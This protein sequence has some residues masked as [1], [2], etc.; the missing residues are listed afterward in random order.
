MWPAATC[1][2]PTWSN[3]RLT[4]RSLASLPISRRSSACSAGDSRCLPVSKVRSAVTT[5]FSGVAKRSLKEAVPSLRCR[6]GGRSAAAKPTG[7]AM[8]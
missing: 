2:S 8:R 5:P 4:S 7:S 6:D 3:L 1:A